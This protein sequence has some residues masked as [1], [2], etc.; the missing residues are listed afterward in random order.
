MRDFLKFLWGVIVE[1]L[2]DDTVA[3]FFFSICVALAVAC[4]LISLDSTSTTY[5]SYSGALLVLS[6][7]FL[8][9]PKIIYYFKDKR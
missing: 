5:Y 2:A 6:Y 7:I 4:F 9:L 8:R 3:Q 1:D